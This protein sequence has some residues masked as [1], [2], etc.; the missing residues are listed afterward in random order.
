MSFYR[1]DAILFHNMVVYVLRAWFSY[2]V[3]L[4]A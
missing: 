3:V 4:V 2:H 1:D